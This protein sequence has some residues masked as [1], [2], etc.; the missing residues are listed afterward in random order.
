MFT[1]SAFSHLVDGLVAIHRRNRNTALMNDL[2]DVTRRDIGWPERY[3]ISD[4]QE[5]GFK[6]WRAR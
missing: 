3:R 6:F 5:N 4:R 1:I 2:P